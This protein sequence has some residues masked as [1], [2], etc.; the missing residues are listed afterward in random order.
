[1]IKILSKNSFEKVTEGLVKEYDYLNIYTYTNG[2]SNYEVKA[3]MIY[4]EETKEIIGS[5]RWI[6]TK[7][8]SNNM[9]S[10][11]QIDGLKLKRTS[12]EKAMEDGGAF[13]ISK[14]KDTFNK[15]LL[16]NVYLPLSQ[17]QGDIIV[18]TETRNFNKYKCT[19][20]VE[21]EFNV[22]IKTDFIEEIYDVD[23]E[24]ALII[25]ELQKDRELKT[26]RNR[27]E[28]KRKI[29]KIMKSI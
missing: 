5:S 23:R 21:G 28:L 18:E 29:E 9:T 3:I 10:G 7:Y 17:L 8:N 11:I 13:V 14:G 2:R 22:R 26:L 16:C 6:T 12:V 25:D 27:D 19:Y 24:L 1:M 20:Y 4:D 15:N